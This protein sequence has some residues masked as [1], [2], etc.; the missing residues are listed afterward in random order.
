MR[1]ATV[2]ALPVCFDCRSSHSHNVAKQNP[3]ARR[4][5]TPYPY[6]HGAA[7]RQELATLRLW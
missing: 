5:Q 4:I 7:L 6:S 1:L 2:V 3:A